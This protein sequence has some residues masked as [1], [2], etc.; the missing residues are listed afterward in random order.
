MLLHQESIKAEIQS[1]ENKQKGLRSIQKDVSEET[2]TSSKSK[3]KTPQIALKEKESISELSDDESSEDDNKILILNLVIV[4]GDYVVVQHAGKC[5]VVYY[6][7]VIAS[8]NSDEMFTV[9]F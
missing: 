3:L 4:N 9:I 7:A 8:V 5:N 1:V 6:A 2:P